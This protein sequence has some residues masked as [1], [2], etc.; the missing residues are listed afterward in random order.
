MTMKYRKMKRGTKMGNSEHRR[1]YAAIAALVMAAGTTVNVYAEETAD[2]SADAG[3]SAAEVKTENSDYSGNFGKDVKWEYDPESKTLTV[4]GKGPMDYENGN[5]DYTLFYKNHEWAKETEKIVIEDGVESIIM[6]VFRRFVS[7]RSVSIPES[8]KEIG[9]DAF[10][11]CISL[12]EVVIPSGVTRIDWGVFTNCYDLKKVTLSEGLEAIDMNAFKGCCS[13]DSV[14]IPDSVTSIGNEAFKYCLKLKE[15]N[16]PETIENYGENIFDYRQDNEF[17]RLKV[18]G[19]NGRSFAYKNGYQ[20]D[21]DGLVY[22]DTSGVCG[23]YTDWSFDSE[24]GVYTISGTGLAD[25][26]PI[27]GNWTEDVKAIIVKEGVT[28]IGG[29]GL[30]YYFT[31]AESVT[32]PESF[33]GFHEETVNGLSDLAITSITLP[34]KMTVLHAGILHHCEKLKDVKLP[35]NLISIEENAFSGDV[36]LESI[37]IPEKTEKIGQYAFSGCS[38][39][40]VTILSK[41]VRIDDAAFYSCDP[42]MVICGAK[43][44][45][46][47]EYAK[48]HKFKFKALVRGDADGNDVIDISDISILSLGLVGENELNFKQKNVLD[49]DGDHDVDIADLAKLRQYLS[50]KIEKL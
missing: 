5:P 16:L 2:L 46:A 24:T 26:L 38:L 22:S 6:D 39:K 34:D 15:V 44:S 13:L 4:S 14:H 29:N 50:K 8:V 9:A 45:V 36:S 12:E 30:G 35:A 28:G 33:E 11:N 7:L 25:W 41:F 48:K 43:G 27:N 40:E 10:S 31:G 21:I 3:E 47:E 49:V 42:S 37:V 18:F 17:L 19:P 32:L 1:I 20:F 23:E